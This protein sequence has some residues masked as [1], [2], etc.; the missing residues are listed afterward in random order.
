M[1]IFRGPFFG[2][3]YKERNEDTFQEQ[4]KVNLWKSFK[5]NMIQDAIGTTLKM[6][7]V[8]TQSPLVNKYLC[9]KKLVHCQTPK[10]LKCLAKNLLRIT[11]LI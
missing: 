10:P 4:I 3:N 8:W 2:H 7:G 1:Q 5:E 6:S 9:K 11:R